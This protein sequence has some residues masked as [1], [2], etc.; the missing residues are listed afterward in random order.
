MLDQRV[1][2]YLEWSWDYAQA[3]SLQ[4]ESLKGVARAINAGITRGADCSEEDLVDAFLR[5]RVDFDYLQE[6]KL[7]EED[8]WSLSG[9][10]QGE[11]GGLTQAEVE[12]EV[13]SFPNFQELVDQIKKEVV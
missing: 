3:E 5:D 4:E 2:E 1:R 10:I 8:D 13:R 6:L 7:S 12:R 9:G 11:F